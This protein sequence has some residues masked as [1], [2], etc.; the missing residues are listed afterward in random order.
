M[1]GAEH[2]AGWPRAEVSYARFRDWRA[3]S[4]AFD[5]LAAMG[6]SNWTTTLR[7]ADPIAVPYRA[8]K[9]FLAALTDNVRPVAIRRGA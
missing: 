8:V 9:A 7:A 4:I 6:S 1:I 3:R 2:R 5:G